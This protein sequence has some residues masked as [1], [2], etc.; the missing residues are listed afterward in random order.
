LKA[1]VP[2]ESAAP[3]SFEE[4][5]HELE[6]IV[7]KM[8]EGSLGL[9]QSLLAYRRGAELVKHCQKALEAVRDQVMVLDG[10]MLRSLSAE[11]ARGGDAAE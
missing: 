11:D 9:E 3:A 5:I 4:A 6:T 7:A 1:T 10:E 8:D 2:A